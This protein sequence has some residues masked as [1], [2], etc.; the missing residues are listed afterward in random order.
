MSFDFRSVYEK[1]DEY[2]AK[3]GGNFVIA[4]SGGGDSMALLSLCNEWQIQRQNTNQIIQLNACIIDHGIADNSHEIALLAKERS[5][6]IGINAEIFSLGTKINTRL[7]ENARNLRYEALAEFSVLKRAKII[8]LAHN[9][10]DQIETIVFRM[11]RSTGLDGLVG[12]RELNSA[13]F[14][15]NII[16]A[17]PLLGYSRQ[18]LRNYLMVRN[19]EYFDDPANINTRFSRVKI[20]QKLAQLSDA[21]FGFEKLLSI[22]HEAKRLRFELDKSCAFLLATC[23]CNDPKNICLMGIFEKKVPDIIKSRLIGMIIDAHNKKSHKISPHK[24]ENLW[25][26]I[27]PNE[28]SA[29]TLAGV[30]ISRKKDLLCFAY[31]KPRKGQTAIQQ[32]DIEEILDSINKLLW[33]NGALA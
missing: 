6:K 11:S 2:A 30:K 33:H 31:A 28:Q 5:E 20:R 18:E 22:S 3:F 24:I 7:Q 4:L 29:A 26:K 9:K 12:M 19:I 17:R 14:A 16:L 25:N 23:L 15:K 27:K 10:D 13:R 32:M 8:L 21:G 1:L